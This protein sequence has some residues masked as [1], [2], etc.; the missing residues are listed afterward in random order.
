MDTN[1]FNFSNTYTNLPEKLYTN[2]KPSHFPNPEIIIF[3]NELSENLGI[4]IE[5]FDKDKLSQILSG[6]LFPPKSLPISQAYAGHQ[7]GYFTTLGDGRAILLGEHLT[8]DKKIFDIQLKG[9]GRTVYSRG[10]DGKATLAPML[11]EYLIS[12]A[13]YHLNIDTTRSLAVI[14]TGEKVY[15]NQILDGAVLSRVAKSHI[16]VGTFQFALITGI[17]ELKALADYTIKRH[18]PDCENYLDLVKYVLDNQAKLIS[19]WQ[20]AGFIHGVM[21]TDNMSISGETID[22]GPC[23]FMD[24][25]DPKTVFSS[26]DVNGRYRYEN[27]PFIAN[28]NLSRFAEAILPLIDE[29]EE[30][31]IAIL[32]P[33]ITGFK[34]RFEAYYLKQMAKKLGFFSKD[35]DVSKLL[36]EILHLMYK[37]NADFTNTF[38]RLT[39]DINSQNL[40]Y[41]DDTEKLF[42]SDEFKRWKSLWIS[43]LSFQNKSKS[44]IY[45]LMSCVNPFIIPRNSIV[46]KA[47]DKA[48]NGDLTL[49]NDFLSALKSPYDYDMSKSKYQKVIKQ[50]KAYKTYC[51]T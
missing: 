1:I 9:S 24:N 32:S 28:W 17:Y 51:G 38:V 27:Q 30:K 5:D 45:K 34:S 25:Y 14:K 46:E 11:R 36:D 12:E 23:A 3:N 50:E 13:M 47:L 15:R 22:Y 26:I 41:L 37:Y 40:S 8:P 7:F 48:V 49:F 16:R 10:G 31:S 18:Y 42:E 19:K 44:E 43:K 2:A 29:D 21:N 20:S 33:I 4:N 35:E 6:N 39:L